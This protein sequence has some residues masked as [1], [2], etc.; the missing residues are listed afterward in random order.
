[1]FVET[2]SGS[3]ADRA[4][5]AKLME[6]ARKGDVIVCWRLDR[7]GR[8]LRHLIDLSEQ[9]QQRRIA[10]QSLTESIDTSTSSGRFMF[11]IL[12]AL[13]QMVPLSIRSS[14]HVLQLVVCFPMHSPELAAQPRQ[15]DIAPLHHA[16]RLPV[17]TVGVDPGDRVPQRRPC[18]VLLDRPHHAQPAA[19]VAA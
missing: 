18:P 13:G 4:E 17:R 14:V 9:L 5:L 3:R 10:L 16:V 2:G 12:G 19:V 8:S 7:I 11:N 15:I 6:I 1:M